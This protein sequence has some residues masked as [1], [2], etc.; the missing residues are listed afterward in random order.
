MSKQ[1]LITLTLLMFSIFLLVRNVH[2]QKLNY[3]KSKRLN[4][5]VNFFELDSA[6]WG[7]KLEFPNLND[8]YGK[9]WKYQDLTAYSNICV[10]FISG[11]CS[12]CFESEI[13]IWNKLSFDFKNSA[14]SRG[15]IGVNVGNYIDFPVLKDNGVYKRMLGKY[16]DK[17][18]VIAFF[19][20]S[21][22]R[23]IRVHFSERGKREKTVNFVKFI[24]Q[25]LG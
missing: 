10:I 2:L 18:E 20:D 9:I 16:L 15:L 4:E 19:T 5:F 1:V 3:D 21:N 7:K 6:F 14:H 17:F 24:N 22:L 8:Y 11:G 13:E 12:S 23:I 25:F